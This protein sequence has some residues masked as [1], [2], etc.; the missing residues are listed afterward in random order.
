M[1][2]KVKDVIQ[3]MKKYPVD[4]YTNII[5]VKKTGTKILFEVEDAQRLSRK[6]IQTVAEKTE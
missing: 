1:T 2:F 4:F 3:E 6:G 5:G